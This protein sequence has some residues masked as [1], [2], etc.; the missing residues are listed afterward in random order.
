MFVFKGIYRAVLIN[1]P[2]LAERDDL[3]RSRLHPA[4]TGGRKSETEEKGT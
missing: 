4:L 2:D 1:Y 3:I